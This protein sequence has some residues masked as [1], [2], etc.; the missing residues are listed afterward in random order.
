M[1][2]DL[3]HEV[4]KEIPQSFTAGYLT[5]KQQLNVI[6]VRSAFIFYAASRI[7]KEVAVNSRLGSNKV[8][9]SPDQVRSRCR[10]FFRHDFL[11]GA[12]WKGILV[13]SKL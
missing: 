3:G 6:R 10:L 5:L 13:K 8:C 9:V 11:K 7:R 4:A 1:K 2:T 12:K